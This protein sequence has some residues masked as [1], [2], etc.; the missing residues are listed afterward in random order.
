MKEM[1]RD[2]P[3]NYFRSVGEA[4][5]VE[6]M[7]RRRARL[8]DEGTIWRARAHDRREL[9]E[10]ENRRARDEQKNSCAAPALYAAVMESNIDALMTT[11]HWA[12]SRT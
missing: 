10:A 11:I 8:L 12:S 1:K 5:A 2:I 7:A 9:Q 3:Y 4:M 6:A